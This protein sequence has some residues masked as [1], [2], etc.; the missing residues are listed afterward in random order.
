M[1]LVWVDTCTA[2]CQDGGS[3]TALESGCTCL[4]GVTSTRRSDR[5]GSI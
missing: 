5:K 1:M 2:P 3:Q 4:E